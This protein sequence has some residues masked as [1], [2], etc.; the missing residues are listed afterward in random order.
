MKQHPLCTDCERETPTSW[1]CR[2]PR[3]EAGVGGAAKR[4]GSFLGDRER[5]WAGLLWRASSGNRPCAAT[6]SRQRARK[7]QPR[8]R[9]ATT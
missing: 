2:F 6:H 5:C 1:T 9:A 3:A 4:A 7:A 8:C